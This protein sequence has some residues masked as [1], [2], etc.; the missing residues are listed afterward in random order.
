[1]LKRFYFCGIQFKYIVFLGALKLEKAVL[2][3][4]CD[5]CDKRYTR[6]DTYSRHVRLECGITSKYECHVC[7]SK[8]KRR[9]NL[10][11]HFRLKHRD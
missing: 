11:T 6:K 9:D 2:Q 8:Y 1:M 5:R 10:V 3:Y 7:N 4:R